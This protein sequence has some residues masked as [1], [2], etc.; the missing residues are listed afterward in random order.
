LL[1]IGLGGRA[2]IELTA[3]RVSSTPQ[4][5]HLRYRVEGRAPLVLDDRGR[6]G[7]TPA[8]AG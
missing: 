7:A 5:T 1:D 8:A 2:G 4:V 3:L 6:S